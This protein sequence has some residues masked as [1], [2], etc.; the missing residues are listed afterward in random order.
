MAWLLLIFVALACGSAF[1]LRGSEIWDRWTRT[2]TSG[3]RALW[4][5]VAGLS[6][7]SVSLDPMAAI[8]LLLLYFAAIIGWPAS[9][10]LG[11]N[12]GTWAR[13]FALMLARGLLFTLPAGAVMI[14]AQGWAFLPFALSGLLAAPLYEIAWRVP[15][16]WDYLR[17]GPPLGEFLF[18]A[19]IGGS[20]GMAGFLL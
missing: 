12:E 8:A 10:D 7:Y 1:R 15:V 2:G 11:R 19:A 9:I 6:L 20:I 18:G 4:A 17:Q 16:R 3:G 13:D 5:G 14:H